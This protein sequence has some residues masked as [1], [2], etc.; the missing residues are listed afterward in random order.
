[1]DRTVTVAV[2]GAQEECVWTGPLQLRLE[3]LR[4]IAI[5]YPSA[6]LLMVL[7]Y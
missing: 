1:V 4:K 7:K 2:G 3:A 5:S 6:R